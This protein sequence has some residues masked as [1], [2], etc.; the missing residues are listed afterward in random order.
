MHQYHGF[1]PEGHTSNC[2]HR[3][4][5]DPDMSVLSEEEELYT[6]TMLLLAIFRAHLTVFLVCTVA[7]RI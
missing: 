5:D 7:A 6:F 1:C 3:S 2:Q 4:V